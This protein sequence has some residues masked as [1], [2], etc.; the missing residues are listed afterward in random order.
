MDGLPQELH[1]LLHIL[2]NKKGHFVYSNKKGSLS[3]L[4][5]SVINNFV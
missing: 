2:V 3:V 4:Q 5:K 1:V